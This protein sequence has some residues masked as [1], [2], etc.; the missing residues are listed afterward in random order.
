MYCVV[1]EGESV[2]VTKPY[3]NEAATARLR[4][5]PSARPADS[6]SSIAASVRTRQVSS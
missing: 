6:R 3:L 2:L 5:K 1:D 4:R